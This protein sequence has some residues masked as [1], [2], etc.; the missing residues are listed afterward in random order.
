MCG[1]EYE[2][3]YFAHIE[4]AHHHACSRVCQA[5]AQRKGG[6]FD[7]KKR[8]VMLDRYG[9]DNPQRV[10]AFKEKSRNTNLERYGC[11]VGSQ[12]G[13]VKERARKTNQERFGVDWHTQSENFSIKAKA[14]WR[15]HYGV[16]HPM[17]AAEVK[18]KYDFGE[19]WRK[20]HETKKLNGTY[21]TSNVESKFYTQLVK[22]FGNVERQVPVEHEDGTWL[23][24]FRIGDTYVQFDGEYWH[25]L[26][27]QLNAIKE[28]KSQR[29]LTIVGRYYADRHQDVWFASRYMRLIRIT[30][31]QAKT[32]SD[33]SLCQLLTSVGN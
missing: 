30:D 10:Q 12:S 17:R 6:V 28:S 11:E 1:Q 3:K 8:E 5:I 15:D 32:L 33:D 9:A 18:A 25:G 19:V 31:R 24:D 4:R 16:D 29:D 13:L 7:Q 27:R 2:K 21:A 20:A 14:T 23:I 22:V 26:D